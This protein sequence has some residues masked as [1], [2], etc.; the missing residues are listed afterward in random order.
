MEP[1]SVKAQLPEGRGKRRKPLS[2]WINLYL[3]F[4]S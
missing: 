2:N 4:L 3:A 1:E